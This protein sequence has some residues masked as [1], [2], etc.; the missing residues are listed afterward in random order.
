MNTQTPEA[1]VI[2]LLAWA[3]A[4][5]IEPKE[6]SPNDIYLEF[7]SQRLIRHRDLQPHQKRTAYWIPNRAGLRRLGL[8]T[9]MAKIQGL[10]VVKAA[11]LTGAGEGEVEASLSLINQIRRNMSQAVAA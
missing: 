4:H 5:G 9:R 7:F 8:D 1:Q 11:H 10:T 2:D 6:P 3:K